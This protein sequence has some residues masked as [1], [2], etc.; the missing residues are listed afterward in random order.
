M[1]RRKSLENV[2][3]QKPCTWI[4]FFS[5]CDHTCLRKNWGPSNFF[6]NSVSKQTIYLSG[7]SLNCE[8]VGN[9]QCMA[10]RVRIFSPNMYCDLSVTFIIYFFHGSIRILGWAG[11][12]TEMEEWLGNRLQCTFPTFGISF[13]IHVNEWQQ[14]ML[15]NNE[16]GGYLFSLKSY[17]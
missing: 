14:S 8:D 5:I 16:T 1:C 3:W 2:V 6:Y 17:I 15:V 12:V 4:A 7:F 11:W 13:S 9:G 10:T